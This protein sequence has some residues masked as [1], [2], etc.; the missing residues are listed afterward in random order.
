MT[1]HIAMRPATD[2]DIESIL[3]INS[4]YV[5][6]TVITL[7]ITPKSRDDVAE[8]LAKSSS[9]HLPYVLAVDE[10]S[11]SVAGYCSAH[12]FRNSK[13]GYAHTVEL[14]LFLDNE[15]RGKGIGSKLLRE[16]IGILRRPEKYPEYVGSDLGE[17]RRVRVAIACMS[18]DEKGPKAGYGLKEFYEKFGFEEVGHFK[19]VGHKFGRW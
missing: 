5:H 8:E 11:G 17:S 1:P 18:I 14:S 16:V 2:N 12:R 15:F 19:R 4:Y 6:N 7:S 9:A 3:S 10:S 13:G